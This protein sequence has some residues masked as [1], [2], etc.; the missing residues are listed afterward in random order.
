LNYIK[1]WTKTI[2][3]NKVPLTDVLRFLASRYLL[4]KNSFEINNIV[5]S[6]FDKVLYSTI[7]EIFFTQDYTPTGFKINRGDTVLDIGAHWEVFTAY[8][9][10][11]GAKDVI[12]FE[13]DRNNYKVI[14]S[15]VQRNNLKNISV[16]NIAIANKNGYVTLMSESN[17]R[18]NSI[19]FSQT[20]NPSNI[21][22]EKV[23]T[24]TLNEALKDLSRVDFLKMD[25]EGAEYDVIE[26]CSKETFSKI[27]TLVLEY[28]LFENSRIENLERILS[29]NYSVCIKK[30]PR[31]NKFGYIYCKNTNV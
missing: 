17:S 11:C 2:F 7:K 28:H 23:K 6:N 30:P 18:R 29:E 3:Y 25:I 15:L 26:A 4:K 24:I 16:K 20:D 22:K 19:C 8:A 1:T 12:A 31:N 14:L 21:S 5:F 27:R 10:V 9:K 13:P